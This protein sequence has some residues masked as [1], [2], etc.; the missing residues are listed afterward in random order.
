[1]S[2]YL[3]ASH[4]LS[5]GYARIDAFP[6]IDHLSSDRASVVL[7][8]GASML[9][10][11]VML[12]PPN[13]TCIGRN[14]RGNFMWYTQCIPTTPSGS[15]LSIPKLCKDS[16]PVTVEN[17]NA[18]DGDRSAK[19]LV[20]SSC[21]PSPSAT[22]SPSPL[23][24]IHSCQRILAPLCLPPPSPSHKDIKKGQS[25][26]KACFKCQTTNHLVSSYHDPIRCRR[27]RGLCH[28]SSY[29]PLARRCQTMSNEEAPPIPQS[30]PS[31]LVM[32]VSTP[33][34]KKLLHVHPTLPPTPIVT[35]Q[36]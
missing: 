8:R 9:L 34:H 25:R 7:H 21:S 2:R 16:S 12:P 30:L 6:S 1:M 22:K 11:H 27:C 17:V 3:A 29:C 24:L 35:H 28:R 18:V 33:N 36:P 15:V 26:K 13:C 19:C 31:P 20:S 5:M 23:F 10:A 32:F 4:L 14:D